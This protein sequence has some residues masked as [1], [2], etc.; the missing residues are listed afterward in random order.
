MEY[1]SEGGISIILFSMK[2][3][4]V[5]NTSY[6]FFFIDSCGSVSSCLVGFSWKVA[7]LE[8]FSVLTGLVSSDN[9]GERTGSGI[10]G[11]F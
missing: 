3:S 11:Y 8:I 7:C 10:G 1:Y 4:G 9:S 5:S 6:S 2:S